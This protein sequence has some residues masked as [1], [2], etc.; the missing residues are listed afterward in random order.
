MD[1]LLQGEDLAMDDD[2]FPALFADT[3]PLPAD[4]SANSALRVGRHSRPKEETMLTRASAVAFT[5]GR[6]I[7]C[8]AA[9][10]TLDRHRS[11]NRHRV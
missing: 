6:F 9:F 4:H 5:F 2:Y 7:D 3:H 10:R 1:C 11:R 8:R